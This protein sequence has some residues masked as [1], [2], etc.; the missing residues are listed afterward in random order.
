[1]SVDQDE[2][3]P[4]AFRTV[5]DLDVEAFGSAVRARGRRRPRC[6]PL[7]DR[8]EGPRLH[9]GGAACGRGG[10]SPG[11]HG[12]A[13]RLHPRRA[14]CPGRA[15]SVLDPAVVDAASAVY[16]E[17]IDEEA[18]AGRSA[19]DH[20]AAPG[21]NERLWNSFQKLA[22]R[23]PSTFV[24]YFANPVLDLVC[25]SWLGPGYRMTAQVN[26]V[27]PGGD[28]Q[29]PHRD[30]HLGFL[31]DDEA[32]RTRSRCAGR[33]RCS[34]CRAR[35]PTPTWRSSPA[36]PGCCPSPSATTSVSSP[37][38]T[39]RSRTTSASTSCSC[40]CARVICCSST[41]RCSTPPGTT[42]LPTSSARPTSSRSPP[43]SASPWRPSTRRGSPPLL[44]RPAGAPRARDAGEE[45]EVALT[46]VADGYPFPGN[47]DSTPPTGGLAPPSQRDLLRQAL[48]E[49]WS[50]ERLASALAA[51]QAARGA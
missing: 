13:Q 8:A 34:R 49:A 45:L 4:G 30:Y 19:G 37:T 21:K 29:R 22:E 39:P 47:L 41:R 31:S 9:G 12:R 3:T 18:A 46:M 44:R 28:A 43:R 35:S 14:R 36:P 50:F 27:H 15:R 7:R 40:R 25:E 32:A 2:R 33:Q 11:D 51:Q 23:A 16:R 6:R 24:A 17:L 10:G 20:F 38:G 48:A 5:A 26:V 1:M 42:A